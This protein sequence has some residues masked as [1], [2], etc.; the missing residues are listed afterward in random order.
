VSFNRRQ[1]MMSTAG[2]LL[3]MTHATPTGTASDFDFFHGRWRVS[4]RRLKERL[5]GC[6]EW[7][8]F[9][10][11]CWCQPLLGGA[12]N[13][14]DNIV[15]LPTGTYRAVTLRS[16]DPAT[17]HW[18]IWWLDARHPHS[19]DAPVIGGFENGIG[20]F[21]ARDELGGVPIL[22]RFDWTAGPSPIWEQAFSTDDGASWEIN[23]VM[24]FTA[25]PG[26]PLS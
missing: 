15:D 4:H 13:F 1:F 11:Q 12:G 19:L 10:G 26:G 3:S 22:V 17:R 25:E 14:D 5:V 9:S 20:R 21:Y 2:A 6:T 18:A 23:W 24:H 7:E 8:E 16:L